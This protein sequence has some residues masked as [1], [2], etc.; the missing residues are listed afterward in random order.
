[1]AN[2]SFSINKNSSQNNIK[3]N[4]KNKKVELI[5]KIETINVPEKYT[6]IN[7]NGKEVKFSGILSKT[8]D[9]KAFGKIYKP[10]VTQLIYHPG[11]ESVIGSEEYYSYIDDKMNE[12]IYKGEVSEVKNDNNDITYIGKITITNFIDNQIQIFKEENNI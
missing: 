1:M 12:H 9:N 6:Y 8:I 10:I 7:E 11:V 4:S 5:E 2:F 3:S